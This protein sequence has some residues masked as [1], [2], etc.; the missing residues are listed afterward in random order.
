VGDASYLDLRP[1]GD[2]ERGSEF[3][4]SLPADSHILAAIKIGRQSAEVA[5]LD[6]SVL[7]ER[8]ANG[9]VSLAHK[10]MNGELVLTDSTAKI[11]AF[12]AANATGSGVF[13]EW[14]KM[15][16]LGVKK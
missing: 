12:L 16:K 5:T 9:S 6:D 7:K 8:L 4:R 2:R 11:R 15:E 14:T 3:H 10:F 1:I 13:E